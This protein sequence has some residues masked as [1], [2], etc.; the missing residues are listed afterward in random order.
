MS[1][2][3]RGYLAHHGRRLNHIRQDDNPMNV[4]RQ[5]LQS[6]LE[7]EKAGKTEQAIEELN[8]GVLVAQTDNELRWLGLLT[9]NAALLCAHHGYLDRAKHYYLVCLEHSPRDTRALYGLGDLFLRSGEKENS[10]LYFK[11]CREVSEEEGYRSMLELL[12]DKG[13]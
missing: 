10:E 2:V 6:G 12:G 13:L 7:L 11:R 5:F 9:T 3:V 8:R 4:Y 1:G